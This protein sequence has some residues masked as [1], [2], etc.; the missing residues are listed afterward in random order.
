MLH[1]DTDGHSLY[2]RHT[3]H[4]DSPFLFAYLV[5][6]KIHSQ[7]FLRMSLILYFLMDMH[8]SIKQM[9][10]IPDYTPDTSGTGETRRTHTG[11]I[12][13]GDFR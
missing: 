5:L 13:S 10:R 11:I 2:Q 8:M 7:G 3:Q 4:S 6:H 12:A 1:L 9:D